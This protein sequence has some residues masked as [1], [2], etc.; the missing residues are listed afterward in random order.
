MQERKKKIAFYQQACLVNINVRLFKF[1]AAGN[2][3]PAHNEIIIGH[4]GSIKIKNNVFLLILKL[5]LEIHP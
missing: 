2:G 5:T 1:M 4:V 3:S